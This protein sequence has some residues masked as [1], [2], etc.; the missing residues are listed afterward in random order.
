M[1]GRIRG[2]GRGWAFYNAINY[3]EDIEQPYA[4]GVSLSH[5]PAGRRRHIWT[6]AAARAD[7]DTSQASHKITVAAPT[8]N[9][10]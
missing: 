2:H 5:G 1:C 8:L 3:N 9:M 6:F 4:D 7:G 10:N